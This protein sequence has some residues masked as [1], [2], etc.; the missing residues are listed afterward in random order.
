MDGESNPRENYV[1]NEYVIMGYST[2]VTTIGTMDAD[3]MV[4]FKRPS[5]EQFPL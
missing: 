5:N 3:N 4:F 2:D 1:Y